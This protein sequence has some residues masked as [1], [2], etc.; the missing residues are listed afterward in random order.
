MCLARYDRCDCLR[1]PCINRSGEVEE[2][3]HVGIILG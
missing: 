2:V 3:L 1:H